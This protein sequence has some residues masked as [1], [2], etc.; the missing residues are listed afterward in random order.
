MIAWSSHSY[1]QGEKTNIQTYLNI[2]K[3]I[4]SSFHGSEKKLF[5]KF[6]SKEKLIKIKNN[7]F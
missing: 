4:C 3:M 5:V 7:I 6:L 2:E 1:D